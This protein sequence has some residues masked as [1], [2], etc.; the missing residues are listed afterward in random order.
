MGQRLVWLAE[1]LHKRRLLD[2]IADVSMALSRSIL[3]VPNQSIPLGSLE[4]VYLQI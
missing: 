2:V 1:V 4:A 3:N